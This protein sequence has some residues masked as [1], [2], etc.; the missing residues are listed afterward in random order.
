MRVVID[1]YHH[2]DEAYG[3]ACIEGAGEP[4]LFS[5]WLDLLRLLERPPPPPE[6]RP[7]DKSG[8]DPTG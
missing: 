1:L 6:P 3:Q 4:V 5:S 7:D 2:G 8:A